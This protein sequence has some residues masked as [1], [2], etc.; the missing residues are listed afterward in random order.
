MRDTH[1][2][3]HITE[4]I[5]SKSFIANKCKIIYLQEWNSSVLDY[6]VYR[7]VLGTGLI[8]IPATIRVIRKMA[9]DVVSVNLEILSMSTT[10]IAA[11]DWFNCPTAH[12]RSKDLE[13]DDPVHVN[14]KRTGF[15]VA[16][17]RDTVLMA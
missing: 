14:V 5:K 9:T 12:V 6:E 13:F 17:F 4:K 15:L 8:T 1:R 11:I 10:R 16:P 2:I 7:R 3:M